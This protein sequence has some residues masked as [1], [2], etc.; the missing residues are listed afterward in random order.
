M[1]PD[2]VIAAIEQVAQEVKYV[3]ERWK[4]LTCSKCGKQAPMVRGMAAFDAKDEEDG[5]TRSII[6]SWKPS[7]EGWVCWSGD[8]PQGVHCPECSLKVK[9]QL[10][11]KPN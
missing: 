7:E 9:K 4:P 6:I 2:I 5:I 10:A 11:Q 3:L 8:G 1:E